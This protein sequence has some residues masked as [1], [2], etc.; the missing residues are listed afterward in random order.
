MAERDVLSLAQIGTAAP[1]DD[2]AA[3]QAA[4]RRVVRDRESRCD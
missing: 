4:H 2:G 1:V 3:D